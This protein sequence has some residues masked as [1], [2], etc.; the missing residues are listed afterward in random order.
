M[1]KRDTRTKEGI[2]YVV[3]AF[4]EWCACVRV[5]VCARAHAHKITYTHTR[6][7]GKDLMK[8]SKGSGYGC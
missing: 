1:Y 5:C 3:F 2:G 7:G 6:D 4:Q 8:H